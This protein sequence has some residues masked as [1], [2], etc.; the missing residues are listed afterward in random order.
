MLYGPQLASAGSS[1]RRWPNGLIPVVVPTTHPRYHDIMK[2]LDIVDR[3]TNL[4]FVKRTTETDY[5]EFISDDGCASYYGRKGGRQTVTIGDCV[6]G[7][8]AHEILHAGGI[9]H[10]QARADRDEFVTINWNNIQSGKEH[11]FKKYD[12]E[13]LNGSDIGGYDYGSVMHYGTDFFGKDGKQT[14]SPKKDSVEIGQ[15]RGLSQGDIAG[16]RHMYP[17][18]ARPYT[19]M[20]RTEIGDTRI[21]VDPNSKL[22]YERRKT[23]GIIRQP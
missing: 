17:V 5:V 19:P 9:F 15:R 18:K 20:I 13:D 2:A 1:D 3:D 23:G 22:P 11:N 4:S 6:P 14:I 16:I 12:D 10:E 21:I 8:I 7:S